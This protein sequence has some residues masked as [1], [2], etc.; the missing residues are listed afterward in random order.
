M[1]SSSRG[2]ARAGLAP[3]RQDVR[4]AACPPRSRADTIQPAADSRLRR[5]RSLANCPGS[6]C[7]SPSYS[8]AIFRSGYA[9]STRPMSPSSSNTRNCATGAG[10]PM[11]PKRRRSRVSCGDSA[12]PSASSATRRACAL[13]WPR[14]R[15]RTAALTSS[16]RTMPSR[17]SRS[18]RTTASSVP[19]HRI[20]STAVSTRLAHNHRPRRTSS[21]PRGPERTRTPGPGF[22]R[23]PAGTSTST[24]SLGLAMSG[25]PQ[26]VAALSPVKPAWSG[27]VSPTALTSSR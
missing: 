27:S 9:K 4:D 22:H 14:G 12:V 16:S 26:S 7:H 10:S 20:R 25:P 2:A 19:P 11:R 8:I 1:C 5:F 13:P 15:S 24:G 17:H 18:S 21:W 3:A 6:A 23:V